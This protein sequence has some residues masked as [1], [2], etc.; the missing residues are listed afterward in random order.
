MLGIPGIWWVDLRVD[1]IR[2]GTISKHP[3]LFPQPGNIIAASSTSPLDALYLAAIFDPVYTASYPTTRLVEPISLLQAFVRAF[4]APKLSP[5][6]S[7]NLTDLGTLLKRFPDRVVVVFPEC[8][9]SNGRGILPFSPSLLTAPPWTK[10]F[11][12]S[13]RYT[14]ADITTPLPGRY[15]TFLWNLCGTFAHAINV[16][17]AQSCYNT[18]QRQ[19][20]ESQ[21]SSRTLSSNGSDIASPERANSPRT[22]GVD[23]IHNDESE[24]TREEK[25]FLDKVGESLA[26]VG[27]IKRVGL[28]V[29]EKQAFIQS[30]NKRK[31]S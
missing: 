5:K 29:R 8:T 12:F 20:G 24:M 3:S 15:F 1:G 31:S 16:R 4:S 2:K 9:T 27:R 13:L 10:V 19:D 11:P 14:N 6:S 23:D 17:V 18:S 25:I 21:S 28:G 30:W 7:D 22:G 26:R